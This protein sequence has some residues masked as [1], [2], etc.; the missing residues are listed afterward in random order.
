M[1]EHNKK[2]VAPYDLF[3]RHFKRDPFP[4]F[5]Q[6]RQEVPVYAH[7]A[8]DGSIIWYISRYDDCLAVLLD[9]EN[10]CKDPRNALVTA[11]SPASRKSTIHQAI[12]ENMLFSDP[13]DHT[14]LRSLVK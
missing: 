11:N 10:F 14:R 12:N 2:A 6:M 9:D 1:T 4:T 7:Q 13:P 8:P 5:A 3:S